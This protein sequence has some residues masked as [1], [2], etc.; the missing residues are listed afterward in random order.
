M[1][2]F[3]SL[4]S[5]SKAFALDLNDYVFQALSLKGSGVRSQAT[6]FVRM[7]VPPGIVENGLIVDQAAAVEQLQKA[8]ASAGP[9]PPKSRKVVAALADAHCLLHHFSVPNDQ[10][11]EQMQE[12]VLL[13][14]ER[15]MPIALDSYAWDYQLLTQGK[16]SYEVL[17]AAA[18]A[19]MVA[20]YEQ[21]FALAGFTLAVLEPEALSLSRALIRPNM[22]NEQSV[23][24][25]DLGE[26]GGV[27]LVVDATGLALSISLRKS[28]TYVE[29]AVKEFARARKFYEAKTGQTIGRVVTIGGKSHERG[30][31]A[32]LA[33]ALGVSVEEPLLPIAVEGVGPE[34]LSTLTGLAMRATRLDPGINFIVPT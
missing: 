23:A 10:K 1:S 30:V 29:D 4:F 14:A 12:I 16:D 6:S 2:W 20:Q 24:V 9:Q 19:D 22:L 27:I 8:V 15:R 25:L 3:G 7:D 5:G 34:H 31:Q 11:P 33:K 17:F 26:R 32:S 13:E 28:E 21:T 18:P